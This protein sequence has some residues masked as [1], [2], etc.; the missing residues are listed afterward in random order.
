MSD[1]K[2]F[3]K[4]IDM[5]H[6]DY[7][8]R[9]SYSGLMTKYFRDYLKCT[10]PPG[11]YSFYTNVQKTNDEKIIVKVSISLLPQFRYDRSDINIE[12]W[13]EAVINALNISINDVEY[14]RTEKIDEQGMVRYY[15][16]YS[17]DNNGECN[18]ESVIYRY[19]A[20]KWVSHHLTVVFSI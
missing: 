18:E 7:Q 20:T 2:A 1:L 4:Q 9:K 6:S 5:V 16:A 3:T 8:K 10:L 11:D 14:E 19:H 17:M 13:R 15:G 12:Q